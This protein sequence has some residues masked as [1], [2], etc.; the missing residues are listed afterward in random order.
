MVDLPKYATGVHARVCEAVIGDGWNVKYG[1]TSMKGVKS[2]A[3]QARDTAG[4]P[5]GLIDTAGV[6][7][8]KSFLNK[9]YRPSDLNK[10]LIAVK[11]SPCLPRSGQNPQQNGWYS[12]DTKIPGR[13]IPDLKAPGKTNQQKAKAKAK[14]PK[15]DWGGSASNPGSR[16]T[17]K[18]KKSR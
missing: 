5:G 13:R 12:S 1:V 3:H 6:K 14:Q 9:G 8:M 16:A 10:R 4:R 15:Q 11:T 2:L 18:S 17:P 7:A